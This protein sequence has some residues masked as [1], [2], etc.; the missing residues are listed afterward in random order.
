MSTTSAKS[1]G[2]HHQTRTGQFFTK[3][4]EPIDFKIIAV[5]ILFLAAF[6]IQM[7]FSDAETT[8]P[9]ILID[10]EFTQPQKL[11]LRFRPMGKYAASTF[12]SHIRIPFNYSTLINLQQKMNKRLDNFFD[13]LQ[14]WNFTNIED[15]EKGHHEKHVSVVQGQYQ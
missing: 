11:Q 4:R 14:Q 6:F 7:Q 3:A 12:T 5:N 15:W 10:S 8:K 9:P 1:Q 2:R 13:V